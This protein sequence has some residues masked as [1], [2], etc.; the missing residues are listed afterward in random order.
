MKDLRIKVFDRVGKKEK[1]LLGVVVIPGKDL[2]SG[3]ICNE[4][5][6]TF[7]LR[8]DTMDILRRCK[9]QDN[10]TS[11]VWNSIT[12]I[13][14]SV[15]LP[16][17][18]RNKDSPDTDTDA[19]SDSD[20]DDEMS[21]GSDDDSLYGGAGK[22]KDNF[23]PSCI[24]DDYI[25]GKSGTLA[26]RFRNA[27]I[28]DVGFLKAVSTYNQGFRYARKKKKESL[29][30][31]KKILES[32]MQRVAEIKAHIVSEKSTAYT[33]VLSCEAVGEMIDYRCHGRIFDKGVQRLRVKPGP[34]PNDRLN[35]KFLTK[36]EI[37]ERHIEPS[38]KW[39]EAGS[40]NI[41]EIKLEILSCE[42]LPNKD[43]GQMFGNKTDPFACIVY[44]DCL[45]VT[46]SISDCLNPKWMP[47]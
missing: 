24:D 47:W 34:D 41:G 20:S 21:D 4:T 12:A 5:R 15:R 9:S 6:M 1:T 46:D 33:D 26:L 16:W 18:G 32:N 13:S 29:A 19:Y 17:S 28:D 8:K 42:G 45:V 43:I 2:R 7:K 40:G 11:T 39:V 38:K 22:E 31:V 37:T 30:K 10:F 27:T 36:D 14:P 3:A 44:E 25:F 35:T 23:D